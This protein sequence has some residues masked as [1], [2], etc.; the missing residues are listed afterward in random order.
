ME[1]PA[2]RWLVLG[3]GRSGEAVARYLAEERAAGATLDVTALDGGDSPRLQALAEELRACGLEVR[4]GAEEVDGV[5]DVCV[6]SPGIPPRTLLLRS[7]LAASK[8]LIS[9]VEFGSERSR[10][11]IAAV[12]GTNGKTT[13]TALLAHLLNEAGIPASA[14]GNIG[15]TVTAAARDAT[16]GEVLVAEVSSF[17]LE[18]TERFAPRVAVLL[19]ITPDHLNWHPDMVSYAAA[20][21]KVFKN[22][23]PD[24]TAVVN[25]DDA[26]SRPHAANAE[27]RGIRVCR[28]ST[29]STPA[30]GA[31][32]V[33]GR[34]VVERPSGPAGLARVQDLQLR[35]EHNVANALAAAAAALALGGDPA[36]VAEGLRSFEPVEHRMEP[37]AVIGGAEWFNDSK[38]TNPDAALKALVAFD[39]APVVMLLGGRNKG[40]DFR[41]LAEECTARCEAV[42]VFGEAA[43]ELRGAFA[44]LDVPL[45]RAVNLAGAV[46]EAAAVAHEGDIVLLSPANTSFDEFESYAERGEAFKRLV[47]DLRGGG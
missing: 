21:A 11:P 10:A 12:T 30:G 4:L 27:E 39:D 35:G 14:V 47:L 28:V 23:G 33:G 18:F 2:G 32:V 20:K 40:V 37:I 41:P 25:I 6:T 42:V 7:A 15:P 1:R 34:L 13:T 22:Q 45:R 8:R 31:Y 19:N 24:D 26:G 36:R 3:L 38:A 16:E 29:V 44:G 9:E 5:Y 46:R 17:Q 43:E